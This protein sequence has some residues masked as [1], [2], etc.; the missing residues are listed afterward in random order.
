MKPKWFLTVIHQ[1][2]GLGS[3][4]IIFSELNKEFTGLGVMAQGFIQV[5][6]KGAGS[7]GDY[8]LQEFKSQ[9]L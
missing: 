2:G 7:K 6:S 9:E 5:K 4:I 3:N 8:M 1:V